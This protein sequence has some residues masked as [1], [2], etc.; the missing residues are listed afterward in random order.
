[1]LDDGFDNKEL[2]PTESRHHVWRV[3]QGDAEFAIKEY[4]V[5]QASDLCTCLKEAAIICR[6]R[7][8]AIVEIKALFQ[9]EDKNS[10]YFQMPWHQHGS[11]DKW[12]VE[13]RRGLLHQS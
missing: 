5:A 7:H 6:Q 4:R 11:L 2:A 1:L 3:R 13:G 10:F 8:L 9:G 12:V